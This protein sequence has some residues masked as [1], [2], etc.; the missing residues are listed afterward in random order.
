METQTTDSDQ[1]SA[2]SD[3]AKGGFKK[4]RLHGEL[5]ATSILAMLRD[6]NAHGYELGK[7]LADAGLPPFDSGTIYRTLRQ[8]E[9][10]G[11]IS[12]FWDMSPSGPA[13]RMYSLTRT[14]E[15]F[16]SGW[17]DM[18]QRY[19]NLLSSAATNLREKIEEKRASGE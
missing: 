13:R 10:E 8:L 7:R 17:V 14:G 15:L 18:L 5:L 4:P 6:W 9:K 1:A 2:D 16:L 12:S 11:L 3:Q 19:Q